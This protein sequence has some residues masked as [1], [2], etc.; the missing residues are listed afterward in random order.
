MQTLNIHQTKITACQN[1]GGWGRMRMYAKASNR[2]IDTN[3][4]S[5]IR[6]TNQIMANIKKVRPSISSMLI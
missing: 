3:P 2:K 1:S 5:S 6:V 4:L